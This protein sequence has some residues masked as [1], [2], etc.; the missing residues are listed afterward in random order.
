[1]P[2]VIKVIRRK[3]SQPNEW[4]TDL[5]GKFLDDRHYDTLVRGADADVYKPDGTLLLRFKAG[6][7]PASICLAAYPALVRAAVPSFNRGMAAGGGRPH[8]VKRDGILS[9]TR[10]ARP[11]LSG[12]MGFMDRYPRIPYC[13]TTTYTRD[14]VQGWA[15]VQPFLQA[16]NGAFMRGCPPR[17][18]AQN[19]IIQVT[20]PYYRIPGTAFTTVTVNRNFRTAAHTDTG[21]LKAGFGVMAVVE[22]PGHYDGCYLVFPKYAVAVDMRTCDVLLADVHEV[23]GNTPIIGEL[24]GYDRISCVFYYRTGMRYCGTPAQE[25]A[26]ARRLGA[27][28]R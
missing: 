28:P 26:R 25:W 24:D 19:H 2:D 22:G 9:A 12:V 10:E 4:V 27:D 17:H 15:D 18:N 13:R 8:R 1:M 16:V 5:A 21:D 23:H 14:D 3:W 11:V 20:H 6:V 7:L